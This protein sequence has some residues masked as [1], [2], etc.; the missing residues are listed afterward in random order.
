MSGT[1]PFRSDRTCWAVVG[2]TCVK[3]LALGAA[4]GDPVARISARAIGWLGIRMATVGKPAVMSLGTHGFAGRINVSGP[5]QKASVSLYAIGG[6]SAVNVSRLLL[7]AIWTIR[8]SLKGRS[9]AAKMFS[10]AW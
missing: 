2:L 5:G 6:T 8:G 1:R 9:F 10:M 7:S 4:I 3:R